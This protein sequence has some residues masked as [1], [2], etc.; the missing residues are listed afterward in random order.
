M[1]TEGTNGGTMGV[2][3]GN[4]RLAEG[5][6]DGFQF[7]VRCFCCR[8]SPATPGFSM[9]ECEAG[10]G[11]YLRQF[12]QPRQSLVSKISTLCGESPT[13][14]WAEPKIGSRNPPEKLAAQAFH[15]CCP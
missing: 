12:A 14:E 8:R 9:D 10:Q 13:T 4:D 11:D 15:P 3:I 6:V 5:G 7:C 1:S 2:P